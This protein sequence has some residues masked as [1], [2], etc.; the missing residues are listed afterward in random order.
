ME[1]WN[2][3]QGYTLR[4]KKKGGETTSMIWKEKGACS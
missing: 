3:K 4:C 2:T 1:K